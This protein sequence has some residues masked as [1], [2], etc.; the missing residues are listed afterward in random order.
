[1]VVILPSTS[2][3]LTAVRAEL[4]NELVELINVD[5]ADFINLSTNLVGLDKNIDEIRAPLLII[6]QEIEV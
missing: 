5:Y 4:K 1:M 6:R 3:K 2:K